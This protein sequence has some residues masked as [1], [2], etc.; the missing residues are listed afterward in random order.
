MTIIDAPASRVGRTLISDQ[1]FER[2][3]ARIRAEHPELAEGMPERIM[4][5]A[6]GFLGTCAV[7]DRAIGPSD[8]VDIGWHTFILYTREY[9]AFCDQVAG[10]FIHHVPDDLPVDTETLPIPDDLPSGEP[11]PA[12]A[13]RL[14][15]SIT[16]I[17]QAGYSIDMPL[18]RGEAACDSGGDGSGTGSCSQCH[19]GCTDS[20]KP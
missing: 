4:D 7:T 12:E 5:Q 1:L 11:R 6:L 19:Q 14:S 13:P 10:R 20:P 18:W 15:D 8:L 3:T 9:Q 17:R 2:L 16:A